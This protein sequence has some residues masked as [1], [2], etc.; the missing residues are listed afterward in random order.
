MPKEPG[1][2]INQNNLGFFEFFEEAGSDVIVGNA[3]NLAVLNRVIEW[4][5]HCSSKAIERFP[6]VTTLESYLSEQHYLLSLRGSHLDGDRFVL[7][8]MQ[9]QAIWQTIVKENLSLDWPSSIQVARE[10]RAAWKAQ[11]YWE[12][13]SRKLEENVSSSPQPFLKL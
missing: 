4:M 3:R 7:T 9:E 11:S 6:K 1:F 2:Q 12:L 5:A 13:N 10:L 8:P